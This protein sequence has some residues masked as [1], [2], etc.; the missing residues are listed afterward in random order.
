MEAYD[1]AERWHLAG[2]NLLII[3]SNII[4]TQ[5]RKDLDSAYRYGGDEFVLMFPETDE[6]G[7]YILRFDEP[8]GVTVKRFCR[9]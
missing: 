9:N 2:D 1:N 7:S 6:N 8:Q 3:L 4:K 5:I